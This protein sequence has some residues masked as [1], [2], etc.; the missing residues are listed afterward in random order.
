MIGFEFV[1]IEY[2]FSKSQI[3]FMI[4]KVILGLF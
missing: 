2:R 4:F 1:D 3:F